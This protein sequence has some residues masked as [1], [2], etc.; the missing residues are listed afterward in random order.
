MFTFSDCDCDEKG[1]ENLVCENK[2]GQ[3]PCIKNVTGKKC[4]KC[5]EGKY[6]F[7]NGPCEKDCKCDPLGSMNK[8]CENNGDCLCKTNIVG[9][10]CDQCAIEHYNFP[11]CTGI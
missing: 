10:S 2:T 11:D 6:D 8:H 4:D 9:E 7:E 5:E 3:C 1:S